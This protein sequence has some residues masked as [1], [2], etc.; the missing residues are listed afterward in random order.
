[1]T[2]AAHF[3]AERSIQAEFMKTLDVLLIE[4]NDTDA[5]KASRLLARM[6]TSTSVE[7]CATLQA[8]LDCIER[9]PPSVILLDL[10]LPDAVR[11][12][13]PARLLA[14]YQSIPIVLVTGSNDRELAL[15]AIELGAQDF[16]NKDSIDLE[17]LDRTIRHAIARHAIKDQLRESLRRIEYNNEEFENFA[18]AVAHDLRS[19]VRTA[20]LLADRLIAG[21]R[22]GEG[23]PHDMAS[24]LDNV[25]GHLDDVILSMLDYTG[26]RT[27]DRSTE[28]VH[29]AP[30]IG[31]VTK[32]LEAD[33]V[34]S[35]GHV[36]LEIEEDLAVRGGSPFVWRVIENLLSNAIKY[37]DPS[38][39][40]EVT[41]S[42]VASGDR[43]TISVQDNGIGVPADKR[44]QVFRMLEQLGDTD[45]Q[46]L[47]LAVCRQ[48][49][50]SLDG[51]I[52]I[53]PGEMTGTKV[54]IDLPRHWSG[55]GADQ[56]SKIAA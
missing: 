7:R 51:S 3:D 22:S 31:D 34:S 20:R 30:L 13:G 37:R 14:K 47:G 53:E 43:V 21:V 1:M 9:N 12:E 28:I 11:L 42:A 49:V 15:E 2:S 44:E 26:L 52:W 4:D 39:E 25:L 35:S 33:L 56:Q 5:E 38:R 40:L 50:N 18:S 19:P 29:L 48:I 8:G 6:S 27:S 36:T 46:G 16:L 23:D 54:V 24:R 45:G 32:A 10:H 55:A 41:F 17:Y